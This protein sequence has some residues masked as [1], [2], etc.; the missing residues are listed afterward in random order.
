MWVWPWGIDLQP[1]P[2]SVLH[3]QLQ[4]MLIVSCN[5]TRYTLF[6][7][8]LLMVLPSMALQR[9]FQECDASFF[10]A[11]YEHEKVVNSWTQLFTSDYCPKWLSNKQNLPA[12]WD[13]KKGSYKIA[14]AWFQLSALHHFCDSTPNFT[15]FTVFV[16]PFITGIPPL[17]SYICYCCSKLST[18]PV[19]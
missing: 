16:S 19:S 17:S 15:N 2:S 6:N 1:C 14:I 8:F 12:Q 3:S 7:T 10:I 9:F 13:P 5:P 11:W 18:L 4:Y